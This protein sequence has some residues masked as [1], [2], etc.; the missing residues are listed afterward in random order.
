[1]RVLL[2]GAD[3]F[4]GRRV[5]DRLL[6]DQELQVTVLGRRDSADIR[7]DLTTGSPGALARFL[8]AVAPQVVINCAGATYG[9]SRTLIRSNT[10]AVATVCEAIRRSREPARLVHVGSAAE[11]GP[12]PGGVPVSEQAEPRPVGPYGVSKLAGTE[13]V[14]ASGLDA[15]VLRVFDV[16]GPGSPTASLFGR[17]AEGL[18]RALERDEGQVRMPDLSG[19]RDFVDVRDV[20]RAIQA[21]AV[22]AATGVINIGSGHAVR[23]RDAAQLLVRASG[24]EGSIVEENRQVLLPAQ[25]GGAGGD[26]GPGHHHQP[27]PYLPGHRAEGHRGDGHRAEGLRPE[28][29]VV[30][31]E[32]VPWRQ[33][34]VRTARDRLGWRTQVPLEESLGD[35]W[36][37]TACRV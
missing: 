31:G 10:L 32:P 34:D 7:F 13:L 11:Y 27:G 22:S 29:R 37:E 5:T 3:G 9:S 2:L 15:A 28:G 17:L 1:M 18:R 30:S 6:M 4:I 20:A 33:A 36:L 8:D 24:F 25:V 14:L 35:V 12:V 23:A 16:V 19:Y 21:A 26:H